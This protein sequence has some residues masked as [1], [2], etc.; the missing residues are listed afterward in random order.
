MSEERENRKRKSELEET[1]PNAKKPRLNPEACENLKKEV[2]SL[3]K[4]L[5]IPED[6]QRISPDCKEVNL[7]N[8]SSMI[9]SLDHK[10]R[11]DF[12]SKVVTLVDHN[13]IESLN[14]RRSLFVD[15]HFTA[16]FTVL[17]KN[18]SLKILNVSGNSLPRNTFLMLIDALSHNTTLKV[19]IVNNHSSFCR[20]EFFPLLANNQTLTELDLSNEKIEKSALREDEEVSQDEDKEQLGCM[21]SVGASAL[22]AILQQGNT[23]PLKKLRLSG[24]NIREGIRYIAEILNKTVLEEISLD[25]NFLDDG[26][27]HAF[28]NYGLCHASIINLDLSNNL[29]TDI[30]A[31]M[32]INML[33]NETIK[34]NLTLMQLHVG[35]NNISEEIQKE[36]EAIMEKR[37]YDRALNR[38]VVEVKN[39]SQKL[40]LV[41]KQTGFFRQL[42]IEIVHKILAFTADPHPEEQ[43]K[44]FEEIAADH[45]KSLK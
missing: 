14:L 41:S 2:Q 40:M 44:I 13:I 30:S 38:G 18:T 24:Q 9:Y 5:K 16:L 21:G 25:N 42:P 3:I 17:K 34:I 43:Q 15:L 8:L 36:I 10:R 26:D 19:L 33:K 1:G 29:I 22:S 39:N 28:I 23:K 11:T 4:V 6:K 7:E 35:G 27:I 12:C 45:F 20:P 32:L 31:K 37:R